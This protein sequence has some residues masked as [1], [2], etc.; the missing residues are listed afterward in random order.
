[1]EFECEV[2]SEL[3]HLLKSGLLY[4]HSFLLSRKRPSSVRFLPQKSRDLVTHTAHLLRK[5]RL[6]A[7]AEE[8]TG[9]L[10][11]NCDRR[12]RHVGGSSERESGVCHGVS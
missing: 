2:S 6:K 1:M 11:G 5:I 7:V 3:L 4:S 8:A 12:M 10:Q 9:D